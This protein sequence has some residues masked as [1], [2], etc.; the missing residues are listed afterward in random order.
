MKPP[1]LSGAFFTSVEDIIHRYMPIITQF[2]CLSVS[3]SFC[4]F[5]I[6]PFFQGS[7]PSQSVALVQKRPR[8]ALGLSNCRHLL[9]QSGLQGIEGIINIV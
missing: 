6:L 9:Q 5:V 8:I 1:Q 3:Y 7:C 2:F 4:F